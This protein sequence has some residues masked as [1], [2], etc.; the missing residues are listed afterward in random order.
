MNYCEAR[1]WEIK[2]PGAAVTVDGHHDQLS[3][4][5]SRIFI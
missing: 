4:G 1:E 5:K 2:G 3:R